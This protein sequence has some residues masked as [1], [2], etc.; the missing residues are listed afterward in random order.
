[1]T[2]ALLIRQV[3]ENEN[4]WPDDIFQIK[5]IRIFDIIIHGY[6]PY[7]KVNSLGNIRPKISQHRCTSL[8]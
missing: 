5:T 4:M 1:M 3:I 6:H 2:K 7:Y 8:R